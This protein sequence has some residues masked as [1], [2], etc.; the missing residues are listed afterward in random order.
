M[1]NMHRSRKFTARENGELAWQAGESLSNNPYDVGSRP[2]MDWRAG[3]NDA[4]EA[5][6]A[7]EFF[8]DFGEPI[9]SGGWIGS[10]DYMDERRAMGLT[11]LD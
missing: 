9:G 1:P 3:W 4:D 11:A 5:Y 8:E 2:Y 10:T 7:A 6:E